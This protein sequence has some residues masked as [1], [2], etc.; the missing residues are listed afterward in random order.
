MKIYMHNL[1]LTNDEIMALK[2]LL[3]VSPSVC[4]SGCVYRHMAN[5]KK[6]CAECEFTL[7]VQS[8][9]DKVLGND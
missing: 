2:E 6:D 7:S 1:S 4:S 9:S 3:V 8:I 5:S